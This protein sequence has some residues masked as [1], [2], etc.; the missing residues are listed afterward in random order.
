MNAVEMKVASKMGPD[1]ERRFSNA[2]CSMR[3]TD[4]AA[5]AEKHSPEEDVLAPCNETAAALDA[6]PGIAS[7]LRVRS[8][9]RVVVLTCVN[10]DPPM[11]DWIY[12]CS[13]ALTLHPSTKS[14][15]LPIFGKRCAQALVDA[16]S[17]LPKT[18]LSCTRNFF[19][20]EEECVSSSSSDSESMSGCKSIS[21]S[22][23][24]GDG[25]H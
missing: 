10:G 1:C 12:L 17:A 7:K 6:A 19:Q 9:V 3:L 8:D 11:S 20:V 4:L 25:A 13:A 15:W 21:S 24:H 5:M 23:S 14:H 18:A 2:A 22:S 16:L